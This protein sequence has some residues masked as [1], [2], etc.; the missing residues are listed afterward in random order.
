MGWLMWCPY[1]VP[2]KTR[3][4]LPLCRPLEVH[5]LLGEDLRARLEDDPIVL[6]VPAI[7]LHLTLFGIISMLS[8]ERQAQYHRPAVIAVELGRLRVLR[9]WL[10]ADLPVAPPP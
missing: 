7:L 4:G 6:R 3:V 2:S 8:R 9:R 5:H 10:L 1:R